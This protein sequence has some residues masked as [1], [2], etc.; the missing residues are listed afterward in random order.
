[1]FFKGNGGVR[2]IT[3]VVASRKSSRRGAPER[4][5]GDRAA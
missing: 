5:D 2:S 3:E 1:M 4:F